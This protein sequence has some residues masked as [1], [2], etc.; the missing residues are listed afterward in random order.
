MAAPTMTAPPFDRAAAGDGMPLDIGVYDG[1]EERMLP[2]GH[3]VK[4]SLSPKKAVALLVLF[5]LGLQS[6]RTL[7]TLDFSLNS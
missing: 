2:V 4:R 6:M 5:K 1:V 7:D 3:P